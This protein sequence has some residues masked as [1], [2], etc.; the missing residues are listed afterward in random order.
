M[1]ETPKTLNCARCGKPLVP[2]GGNGPR[3][4]TCCSVPTPTRSLTGGDGLAGWRAAATKG[5]ASQMR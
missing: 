3:M 1:G 2:P 5:I 4:P